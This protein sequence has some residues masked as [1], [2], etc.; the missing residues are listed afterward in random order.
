MSCCNLETDRL[1]LRPPHAADIEPMLPLI[2]DWDVAK[3]LSR[4][5]HPYSAQD[6]KDYLARSTQ[7]RAKGEDFGFAILR[8]WDGAFMGGCGVHLR[9]G[10]FELGYWLG[11]RYWGHGY[12]TDAA[13]RLVSFAFRELKIDRLMAGWFHDNPASGHVLEKL[14]F[15]PAGMEDRD[16]VA[17]GHAMR[18]HV[19]SLSAADFTRQKKAEAA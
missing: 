6:A 17:R 5:P 14:G 7:A 15:V 2:G 10:H 9:P 13:R 11:K 4:V 12:A 1:I 19:V 3:N 18:C 8:K 16:C